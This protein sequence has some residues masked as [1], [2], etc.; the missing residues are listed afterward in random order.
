MKFPVGTCKFD[1]KYIFS[2][3]HILF[4]IGHGCYHVFKIFLIDASASGKRRICLPY[5]HQRLP[6]LTCAV[7][8]TATMFA[9]GVAVIDEVAPGSP[10]LLLRPDIKAYNIIKCS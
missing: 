3:L 1:E 10:L 8:A 7:L 4:P 9:L 6:D 2:D 5:G